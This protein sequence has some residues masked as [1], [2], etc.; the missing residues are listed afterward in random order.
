MKI[1]K[2]RALLKTAYQSQLEALEKVEAENKQYDRQSERE[3]KT[4]INSK[5]LKLAGQI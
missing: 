4:S 5:L 2:L 3:I 1:D